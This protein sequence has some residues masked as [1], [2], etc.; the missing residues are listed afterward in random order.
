MAK[1]LNITD[2]RKHLLQLVG[3]I[4]KTGAAIITKDYK[5][6]AVLSSIDGY[7]D[8]LKSANRLPALIVLGAR[9]C[10]KAAAFKS[11]KS[12]N[13]AAAGSFSKI[14]FVYGPET[15]KYCRLFQA[16][17][18]R[19]VFNEKNDQP[20]I[21]SVKR[22]LTAVSEADEFFVI[23]FLSQTQPKEIL[24]RLSGKTAGQPR[25]RIIITRKNGMPVHPVAFSR[26]Y[27]KTFIETRKELGIPHIVKKFSKDV[28][29][30]DV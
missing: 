10:G 2:A 27:I 16:K 20:I 30:M 17:D 25:N 8:R 7:E 21:T 23:T 12:I 11:I 5:P 1:V 18:L 9:S 24:I 19:F 6:V 22:A 14:I 13:A 4:N 28:G 15:E 29:Y 3:S 26:D